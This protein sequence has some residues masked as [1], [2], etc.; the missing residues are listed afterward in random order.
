M[1]GEHR[2]HQIETRSITIMGVVNTIVKP[3]MAI[4]TRVAFTSRWYRAFVLL[5]GS[6]DWFFLFSKLLVLFVVSVGSLNKEG[7]SY[8]MIVN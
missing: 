4:V 8:K 5:D 6:N 7:F 2:G 1:D 3:T